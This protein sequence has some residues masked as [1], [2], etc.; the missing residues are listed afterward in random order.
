MTPLTLLAIGLLVSGVVGTLVPRVPGPLLS[1]AGVYLYWWHTGF[2]EPGMLTVAVLTAAMGLALAGGIVGPMIASRVGGVSTVS[3]TV[4]TVVGAVLFPFFGTLGLVGG[5]VATVF[6]LE[7]L[8]KRDARASLAAGFLVVLISFGSRLMQL[9]LT[10]ALCAVML[11][12]I[13][14]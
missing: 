14:L 12:I 10:G 3:A 6:I 2:S 7:Y 5:I 8:R 13:V 4:G 1:I 11:G 9:V